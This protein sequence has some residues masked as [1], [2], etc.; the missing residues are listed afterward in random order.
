MKLIAYALVFGLVVAWQYSPWLVFVAV[1]L[2]GGYLLGAGRRPLQRSAPDA[3][4]ESGKAWGAPTY[5]RLEA[6][7]FR[8]EEIA[9]LARKARQLGV[10]DVEGYVIRGLV[11]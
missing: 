10:A 5:P 9:P 6:M 11:L 4:L 2:L 1:A 7:G 3:I 8:P